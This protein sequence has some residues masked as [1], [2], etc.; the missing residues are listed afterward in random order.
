MSVF[1]NRIVALIAS[2]LVATAATMLDGAA[3]QF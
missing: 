1:T 3:S 2:V